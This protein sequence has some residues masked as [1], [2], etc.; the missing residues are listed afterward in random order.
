MHNCAAFG[1][2]GVTYLTMLFGHWLAMLKLDY[3]N[4]LT[5]GLPDTMIS[6]LERLQKTAAR[7]VTRTARH[8]HFTPVAAIK[9]PCSV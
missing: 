8:N 1:V 9:I 6:K 3:S 5:H 7:I 4:A 2:S